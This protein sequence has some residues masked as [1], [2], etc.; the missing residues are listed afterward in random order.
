MW[1]IVDGP[2]SHRLSDGVGYVWLVGRD[3]GEQRTV[4][5]EISET[6]RCSSDLPSPLPEIIATNGAHAVI[7]FKHWTK[8]P[9]IVRVSSIAVRPFPGSE[10]PST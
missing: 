4:R 10:D 6:A 5:V 9:Q 7:G 2:A 1:S 8:P 3:D